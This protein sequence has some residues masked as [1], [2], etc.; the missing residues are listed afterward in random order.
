MSKQLSGSPSN[1]GKNLK[2]ISI[3]VA[4]AV[5]LYIVVI[6]Y[7][8]SISVFLSFKPANW[9]IAR[10]YKQIELPAG[11][12]AGSVVAS[13]DLVDSDP[14]V[15]YSYSTSK[16]VDETRQ[17]LIDDVRK[18]GYQTTLSKTPATDSRGAYRYD[19][20]NLQNRV[21]LEIA[22]KAE[23]GGKTTITIIADKNYV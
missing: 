16:G 11:L 9:Q 6:Y 14:S 18:S 15:S 22:I 8:G 2:A 13:T 21:H 3:I 20:Y 1:A 7:L 4:V 23:S 5:G 12:H 19:A 10:Q 17:Q